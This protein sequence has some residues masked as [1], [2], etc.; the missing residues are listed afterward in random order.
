MNVRVWNARLAGPAGS[1]TLL[2]MLLLLS[3][4]GPN[5]CRVRFQGWMNLLDLLPPI[6]LN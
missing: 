4:V 2:R 1:P 5:A 6:L 3:N